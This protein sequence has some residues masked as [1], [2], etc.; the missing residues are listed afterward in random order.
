MPSICHYYVTLRCNDTCEF[1]PHWTVLEN[2]YARAGEE[3]GTKE[4]GA[5]EMEGKLKEIRAKGVKTLNITG[6]EPL[7]RDDLPELLKLAK[8]LG[9]CVELTTNGI[10]Y[11]EKGRLLNGLTDRLFFSLDYPVA[12]EHDRSRGVECFH[13]VMAALELAK[14]A[15]EQ[16]LLACTL[17]RDNIRFLPELAELAEKRQVKVQLNPVN[18]FNGT[19]GFEP[20]TVEAVK[21]YA[22]RKH[23]L[24]NH[25]LLEFVRQGGNRVYWPRCRAAE[26]TVTLLPDGTT[27]A[28][29]FDNRSGRSGRA[30]ICSSCM[31]GPYMLP[32]FAIGLDKYFWLNL[33]SEWLT[34]RKTR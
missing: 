21:Y 32:S 24:V 15:G 9:F 22:R 12:A 19:Q 4:L 10:L 14:T 8:A 25:A 33:W 20:A 6:G 3:L 1:C 31:R 18:D 17:H 7:L 13:A 30:D 34:R 28:P 27:V 16:P 23:V 11:G 2:Q 29:C 26:T 5:R